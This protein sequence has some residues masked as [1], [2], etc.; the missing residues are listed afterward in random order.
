MSNQRSWSPFKLLGIFAAAII[1]LVAGYLL[2]LRA[3]YIDDLVEA[4]GAY[5]LVIGQG[6]DEV[7]SSLPDAISASGHRVEDSYVVLP[8][9]SGADGAAVPLGMTPISSGAVA[10]SLREQ[11][12]WDIYFNESYNDLLRLTF[13]EGRLCKI[14]RHRKNFDLP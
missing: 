7:V 1:L 13:C 10:A 6:K 3:T 8:A 11:D 5:A 12:Q 2:W 14:Y 9:V 4:G